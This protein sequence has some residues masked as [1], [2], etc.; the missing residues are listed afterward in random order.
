MHSPKFV[1]E[2]DPARSPPPSSGTTCTTRCSTTPSWSPGRPTPPA[3]GRRWSS[4]DP[5]GYVVAQHVRRGARPRARPSSSTSSSTST[6][7]RA[8]CT[9]ATAP[10]VAPPTVEHDLR[11]PGKAVAALPRRPYV[12]LGHRRRPPPRRGAATDSDRL[13]TSAP[14]S[15]GPLTATPPR[16]ASTSRR[17]WCC[18]RRTW[19]PQ[20]GYDVVVADT[21]N[22]QLRGCRLADGA[23]RTLAGNGGSGCWMPGRGPALDGRRRLRTRLGPI[24]CVPSSPWDVVWSPRPAPSRSRWPAC[25]SSA[26]STRAP[27][28]SPSRRHHPRGPPRRPGRRGVVR[29]DL[30][31]GRRRRRRRLWVADSETSA[32]RSLVTDDAGARRRDPAVGRACSTSA[33][34]TARPRRRWL[35][36]PLGVTV[37]PDGSVAVARHLQRRG[38]PLRPGHRRGV[39]AGHAGWPSPPT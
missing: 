6:R 34:A 29:P 20:V 39:H 8:R 23:V 26:A 24:R 37:L 1:H 36:H 5:E 12:V 33:S 3:R 15:E 35:Q 10:Y 25:T 2:A 28:P 19:P 11:F 27:A 4:I 13:A 30:R 31:P 17:A 16:H 22:H 18:C 14:A 9:A 21:V 32:L 7:P 38:P